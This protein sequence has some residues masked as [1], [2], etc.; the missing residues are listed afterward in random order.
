MKKLLTSTFFF[1]LF[2]SVVFSQTDEIDQLKQDIKNSKGQYF[3]RLTN[4]LAELYLERDAKISLGLVEDLQKEE[5]IKDFPIEK[6]IS[7]YLEARA[8]SILGDYAQADVLFNTSIVLFEKQNLSTLQ[9]KSL[10]GKAMSHIKEEKFEEAKSIL[11]NSIEILKPMETSNELGNAYRELGRTEGYLKNH[12]AEKD[13]LEKAIVIH[14]ELNSTKELSEDYFRIGIYHYDQFQE[15]ETLKYYSMSKKLKES[16]NDIGGLARINNSLGV[17]H[18]EE[19]NYKTSIDYYK[20][21]IDAFQ[22]IGDKQALAIVMNNLGVSYVD[23]GKLDSAYVYH[24]KTLEL[25]KNINYARGEIL[26]Y[27]NIGEVHQFKGDYSI[28]I[29]YYLMA[30]NLSV[31]TEGQPLMRLIYYK[32]GETY[33]ANKTLDSAEYYLKLSEQIRMDLTDANGL[34]N[35]YENLSKLYEERKDYSQALAYH[36]LFKDVQDSI[37]KRQSEQKLAEIQAR[38]DTERQEKEIVQLQQENE[39]KTLWQ[40]ILGIS[41]FLAIALGVLIFSFFKYRNKKNTELLEL[42][43]S[44][45]Q[46]LEELDK[47]KNQFFNNI[48]H[49]F[50]TPL[51]LILG[52]LADL[53]ESVSASKQSM[54]D[55]IER[56]GQR[57][58]K[59]INQLLDLSKLETG[60]LNLKASYVDIVPYLKVWVQSFQSMADLNTIKLNFKSDHR[61]CF[62]YADLE[63]LEEIIINLLSNAFKYTSQGG[64]ISVHLSVL[65]LDN[66]VCIAIKDDGKGIAIEEVD[67]IFDRFYQASN[68]SSENVIGTG[69]G[70]SLAKELAE[71][72]KGDLAVESTLGKGSVFKVFLPMGKD[73]LTGDEITMFSPKIEEIEPALEPSKQVIEEENLDNDELPIVLV[74][75]DNEDLRQYIKSIIHH[76][77]KVHLATDGSEGIEKALELVPDIV[78]SDVMMPKKDGFEVCQTLKND[79]KTCHI[80]IILLTAL[81]NKKDKLQGYEHLADAYLTKPFDKDELLIRLNSLLELRKKMQQQLSLGGLMTPDKLSYTSMDMQ[82]MKK[83]KELIVAEIDNHDFGVE[84]LSKQMLLSRSQ[85][86]RKIKA[87]TNLTPNEYLRNFRL[88]RAMDMLQQQ[89]ATVSEVAYE[90][91]FQNPGYFSKCFQELFGV[92]PSAVSKK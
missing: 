29:Q 10:I 83:L 84:Q 67:R 20:Q 7:I 92:T 87:I 60:H 49:E 78:I 1:C 31:K 74:I 72:H 62:V 89:S 38:F 54:V 33:L 21:S 65:E 80:P 4:R 3:F 68:A 91:G 35:T 70:L 32:L 76:D 27:T 90:V 43:E 19:G 57:L 12:K 17:L 52:P 2:F 73:H 18:S 13:Y 51:T 11:L 85:L 41:T 50:R 22:K 48:S 34:R 82:F 69:I 26:S 23:Q 28:A 25:N 66:H 61:T 88:H 55:A 53:K 75:E 79:L 63:K 14:K 45:R 16:I 40:N 15:E 36:K 9:A 8:R 47:A 24:K 6:A 77:F 44:Q 81:S 86:F 37:S 64:I 30:K 71:L 42:K 56:N 58:L 39:R 5:D 59:L 46:Q